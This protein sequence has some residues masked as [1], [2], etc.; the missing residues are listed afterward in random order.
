MDDQGKPVDI[1]QLDEWSLCKAILRYSALPGT[2]RHHWGTDFDFY[3]GALPKG[4][5]LQLIEDE[6]QH[7]GP[8]AELAHWMMANAEHYGFYFPYRADLGGVA[9]E[10]W[11][12]SYFAVAN[13][14]QGELKEKALAGVTDRCRY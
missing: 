5:Q 14:F 8:C 9:C 1:H 13:N 7:H 10:P 12:I 6:Y 4:Y 11:H 3:D 2:S